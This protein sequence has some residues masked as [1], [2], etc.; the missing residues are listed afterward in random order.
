MKAHRREK[1]WVRSNR[2]LCADTDL[3]VKV[4]VGSLA[5][6]LPSRIYTPDASLHVRPETMTG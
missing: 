4:E 3:G 5:F 6:D 2:E 1:W